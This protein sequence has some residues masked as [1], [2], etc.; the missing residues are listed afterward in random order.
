M[1]FHSLLHTAEHLARTRCCTS[2][3][4]VGGNGESCIYVEDHTPP[5]MG[6]FAKKNL[7]DLLFAKHKRDKNLFGK[8]IDRGPAKLLTT[9]NFEL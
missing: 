6:S 9:N 1:W 8:R 5:V 4:R 3:C 2:F 7:M